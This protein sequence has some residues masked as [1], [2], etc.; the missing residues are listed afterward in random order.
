MKKIKFS[1]LFIY[2][3]FV[4]FGFVL[5]YGIASA[6]SPPLGPPLN[7]EP[8]NTI[9]VSRGGTGATTATGAINALLPPQTSY[10]GKFLTTNGTNSSWADVTGVLP[11]GTSGQTLRYGTSWTA[12]SNLYNDGTNIGV[13]TVSLDSNYKITTSGGGIKA[14]ANIASQPAGYFN[15]S[16]ASGYGLIVNNG[17]VG[18]GITTG[19]NSKLTVAGTVEATGLKLTTAPS[20]GYVL[21]SDVSGVGTWQAPMGGGDGYISSAVASDSGG[22]ITVPAGTN[23]VILVAFQA[24]GGN[25]TTGNSSSGGQIILTKNNGSAVT[26][27]IVYSCQSS[28]SPQTCF[29]LFRASLA[30]T[31]LT[32]KIF[33]QES[34]ISGEVQRP[35]YSVTAYYYSY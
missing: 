15:N 10:P 5:I 33:T 21:T 18:I 19:I 3:I 1:S 12:V 7:T 26:A 27:T 14:E 34:S 32:S 25:A 28:G 22:T 30:G 16:N 31:T 9:G 13:G 11:S 17:N 6:F 8:T 29:R 35:G 24:A 4:V 23:R 2:S 20:A